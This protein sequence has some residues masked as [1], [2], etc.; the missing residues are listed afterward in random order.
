VIG[1]REGCRYCGQDYD[2]ELDGDCRPV[3]ALL[4]AFANGGEY[5]NGVRL[6]AHARLDDGLLDALVVED[7]SV[8]ARFWHARHLAAGTADRAPRVHARQVRH[9]VIRSAEVMEYHVDGEPG[10]ADGP[11]EVT[12]RPRALRIRG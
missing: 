6:S 1:V 5:G 2:V 7:R 11:I 10:T 3:R 8:V 9:A 4:I 12:I